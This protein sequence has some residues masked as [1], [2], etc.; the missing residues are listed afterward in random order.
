MTIS[1]VNLPKPLPYPMHDRPS[2][3]VVALFKWATILML[4][5]VCG[6][7]FINTRMQQET[8]RKRIE[9]FRTAYSDLLTTKQELEAD[10]KKN[11]AQG[12]LEARLAAQN[13]TLARVPVE[14]TETLIPAMTASAR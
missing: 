1:F 2:L 6:C 8:Q 5:V 7:L 4:F 12:I 14:D 9:G 13:S 10:I 3:S 11:R